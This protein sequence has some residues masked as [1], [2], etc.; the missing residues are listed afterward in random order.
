MAIDNGEE[1]PLAKAGHTF[2]FDGPKNQAR[3]KAV[4]KYLVPEGLDLGE[5][6]LAVGREEG[7]TKNRP[8]RGTNTSQSA[9]SLGLSGT[10][11]RMSR[12]LALPGDQ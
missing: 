7:L 5:R 3:D 6:L 12:N 10:H 4:T 11:S 9:L 8:S 2:H 1:L